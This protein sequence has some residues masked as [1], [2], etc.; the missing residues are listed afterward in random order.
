MQNAELTRRSTPLSCFHVAINALVFL[1][2]TGIL[3]TTMTLFFL[4]R[5]DE[6]RAANLAAFLAVLF[7]AA[8]AA[9][10]IVT[11][12]R[13]EKRVPPRGRTTWSTGMAIGVPLMFLT[14][15]IIAFT[16]FLVGINLSS[17]SS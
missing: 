5:L 1:A 17:R 12:Y 7:S 8:S 4:L 11:V 9:S 15:A 13:L 3:V 6:L 2:S 16:T 14:C 10:A